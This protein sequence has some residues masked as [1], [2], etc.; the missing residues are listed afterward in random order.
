MEK[1][2]QKIHHK[3]NKVEKHNIKKG[4]DLVF[5]NSPELEKIGSNEKYS[6]YVGTIFP[7]S[8]IRDILYHGTNSQAYKNILKEGFDLNKSGSNLGYMGKIASFA[9]IKDITNNFTEGPIVPVI[10]NIT[11]EYIN[12]SVE[13]NNEGIKKIKEGLIDSGAVGP[14]IQNIKSFND[15]INSASVNNN[16][17]MKNATEMTKIK[18]Y[19]TMYSEKGIDVCNEILISLG[20]S[21]LRRNEHVI[22]MLDTKQIHILGSD[23]DI[24]SFKKFMNSHS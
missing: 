22:D 5:E 11:S 23:Q 12:D 3:E 17:R 19:L 21:G 7:K 24:E 10:V 16:M 9:T 4:V 1:F 14:F 18:N 2:Q 6:E 20:I 13:L 15:D 8:K